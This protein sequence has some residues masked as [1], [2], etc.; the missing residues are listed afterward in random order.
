MSLSSHRA[1]SWRSWCSIP[2]TRCFDGRRSITPWWIAS[3][4]SV[5]PR[6]VNSGNPLYDFHRDC[7]ESIVVG[8]PRHIASVDDDDNIP[9]LR[10]QRRTELIRLVANTRHRFTVGFVVV[11]NVSRHLQL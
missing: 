10:G 1:S 5:G 9:D 11:V 7:L 8:R 3:R 6:V 4:S 2:T